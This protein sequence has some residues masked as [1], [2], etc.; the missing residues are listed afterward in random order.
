VL[1]CF[2]LAALML[3]ALGVYGVLAYSVSLRTQ[4]F[5]IRAALGSRK[6][7]LMQLVLREASFPVFG[8]VAVG[9]IAALGVTR[10]IQS[11]LYETQT[12]DPLAISTSV[13]LLIVTAFIAALLPAHHAS[14]ADPMQ[15]LR[16]Q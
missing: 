5:G 2:S 6:R 1:S 3:A 10:L 13:A 9:T 4:E 12:A 11:M 14:N 16:E 15:V 8:G 7:D